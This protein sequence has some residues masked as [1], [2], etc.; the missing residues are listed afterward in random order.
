VTN[1]PD[2]V[3]LIAG[4][5]PPGAA[6]GHDHDYARLRLLELFAEHEIRASVANDFHDIERWLPISRMLI[7]YVAGPYMTNEQAAYVRGWLEAGGRWLG[8]HG[9]AGGRAARIEGQR[10]RVMVKTDHHA[11][12]GGFFLNHPPVRR[13]QVDVAA[14]THPLLEGVEHSFVTVDEPYM[15]EV[16][17]PEASTILLTAELGP[18]ISPPGFGFTY[19]KDTALMADG[20]T[21]ALAYTTDVG[22]GGVTYIALGHA[23]TPVTNSQPFVDKSVDPEGKTPP[24]VRV[25]WETP[26]YA[27]LLRN[28]IAWG[29][30]R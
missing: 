28:G 20:K 11:V 24:Y 27:Q 15:I 16:L 22:E 14:P 30:R 26:A 12:L 2:R 3:H 5:F 8:L 23:H 4:G 1:L 13:F 17:R 10:Q 18:D 6:A 21:R 19:E 29:T 25:T 7:T 9:T